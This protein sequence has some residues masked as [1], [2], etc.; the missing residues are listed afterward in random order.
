MAQPIWITPPGNLGT[1]AEGVFFQITLKA[2]DPDPQPG[3]DL[4]YRM[5]A[6]SLPSGVQCTKTGLIIGVPQALSS[7]Q[8]VPSPVSRDITSKFAV[9]AY[10]EKEVNGVQVITHVADQTYTITVSGENPPEFVTPPG[11]IATYYDGTQLQYQ[12]EY[13]DVDPGDIVV[14][15]L[16]AGSLPPG[17]TIDSKGLISGYIIPLTPVDQQPGYSRD[18]QPFDQYPFDFTSFGASTNFQ[19][20]LELTDGKSSNL[21]TFEIY[22]YSRASMTADTTDFTADNTIITADESPVRT[23]IIINYLPGNLG[24]FR[25][26][27][28]FAHQFIGL[29]FD[30]D[31]VEFYV[32]DDSIGLELPPGLQ[33][34]PVTGWLYGD[35]PNLGLVETSYR[36][37][38]RIRKANDVDVFSD[39]YY[40][41][42]SLV[43]AID[44]EVTWLYNSDLGT[45][46]N[47]NTSLF[48]VAA[49]NTGGRPLQYRLKPGDYPVPDTGVYNKLPQGLQLL[50][51]GDIAGRVSFNTFALD[52]G[53]TT[54]D[55]DIKT[56]LVE[57]ETTFDMQ[58]TFTVNAYS[59]DGLISVFKTFTITVVRA[60]NEPY[61]N[62]Y[63]TAMPPQS[64]RDLVDQ[65][66]QNQD[67]IPPELVFRPTDPNFG[68]AT[69]VI[70][71]HAYGLTAATYEEYVQSLYINH[72]WKTL[73]LGS[74]QTAQALDSN[75][76]VIYEVVYSKVVDNLVN[77]SGQSVSK[78]VTLPY[79]V[80]LDG[81]E[82]KTVYPNSLVNMRDQVIDVVGKISNVLPLWMTSKQANGQV[83]GFTPAWVIAYVTP[84]NA[85]RVAYNIKTQFG[86][87]LNKVDFGVD[88]YELDRLLSIHW[89]PLADSV[90]A[91]WVPTPAETTF[92][93]ELHYQ[94]TAI[95]G[96]LGYN[97]GDQIFVPG[98]SIGGLD[99]IND[100]TITVQDVNT[101]GTILLVNLAGEAPMFS[102]GQ[103]FT[104]I[105]GTNIIG[106]G[107]GADFDLV[108]ASGSL[109]VFD[110]TSLRFEAPVDNY[111]NT[112]SFDKYLVFPRR[113]ILA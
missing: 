54:F 25:S 73:T 20:T 34:D 40:F 110:G 71:D 58:F 9:R 41:T 108:V 112:D 12:I 26:G 80:L 101:N 84:G 2:Y 17:L 24:T 96:G 29:D 85:A 33:L 45:I 102:K 79:P 5:I 36:F 89:D 90:N 83:L 39:P 3:E 72:Y 66:I 44:T 103:T 87:Q 30:D 7:L 100:L 81:G 56:R 16:A 31:P 37:A 47:G 99:E 113:T 59:V 105:S 77:T 21:R 42:M 49:V 11:R 107:S 92:D 28:Y 64:D 97:I 18:G 46:N 4:Y 35:I 43:G 13:T 69:K 23:P 48:R 38:I 15:K 78:E 27:N 22:V 75:G 104:N 51:S 14:V 10:T 91:A 67:I 94:V 68:V 53:K 1:V 76:N 93:L 74:I 32:S 61:N 57:D 98:S 52:G 62:L 55:K 86:D 6:G 82:V 63:I 106:T 8:G 60:Y 88:R 111:T 95:T 65:L 70:Y 50:A 19:F 109:T